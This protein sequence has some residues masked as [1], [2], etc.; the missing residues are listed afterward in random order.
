MGLL[1]QC[2]N[3]DGPFLHELV[4]CKDRSRTSAVCML[5]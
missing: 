2:G 5:H 4:I 3:A 1:Y